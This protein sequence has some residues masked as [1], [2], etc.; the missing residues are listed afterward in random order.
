MSDILSNIIYLVSG[1]LLG[2]SY[3]ALFSFIYHPKNSVVDKE[4]R[5]VKK[6]LDI[7][8]W[9]FKFIKRYN[10]IVKFEYLSKGDD[11]TE[12]DMIFE[13]VL[14][15]KQKI[16][17]IKFLDHQITGNKWRENKT[18]LRFLY[19]KI[20]SSYRKEIFQDISK[21]GESIISQN[22]FESDDIKKIKKTN[23]LPSLDELL[24][25]IL[26]EGMG[27]LSKKEIEL[28]KKYN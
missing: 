18:L 14:D 1:I 5:L 26:N 12:K 2:A 8:W 16:I 11:D 13:L 21:Y 27:S 19:E 22:Y 23:T 9:E 20:T 25:K 7:P 6:L 15:V 28:L 4:K 3:L 17:N 24:D 10:D